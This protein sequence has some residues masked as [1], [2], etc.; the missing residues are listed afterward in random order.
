[1]SYLILGLLLFLGV[2]SLRIVAEDWR[3]RTRAR[4]GEQPYKGLYSLVSIAGFALL[5]WGYGQA[6][7]A[8]QPL[9]AKLPGMA[10]L[11]ALLTLLAFVLLAAAYVPRNHLKAR[12]RHPMVL[13]VKTWAL[14]H[15]LANNSLADVLLFGSFLVW[16]ALSFR[17]ARQRDR[18]NPPAPIAASAAGTALTLLV[19]CAAWAGFAFWAHGAWIGVRPLG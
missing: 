4:L 1:M 15:L 8:S 18:A 7:L 16:A 10:H 6:R 19:G 14:A 3:S 17:A 2:H 5:I 12:L 11:A 9:W 13:G